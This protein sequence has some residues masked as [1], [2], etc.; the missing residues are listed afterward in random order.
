MNFVYN[1]FGDDAFRKR[2]SETD[3]RKPINKALFEVLSVSFSLIDEEKLKILELK[4]E[5]FKSKFRKLNNDLKFRYSITSGTGQ[6]ESV[7]TR[8]KEINRIIMETING[9][10][11]QNHN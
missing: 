8:F 2:V 6:K 7:L 1:I 5:T 3:R 10:D 4:A 9:N 11:W